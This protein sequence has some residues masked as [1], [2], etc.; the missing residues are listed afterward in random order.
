MFSPDE[1]TSTTD[2][3]ERIPR[4]FDR[5]SAFTERRQNILQQK[6]TDALPSLTQETSGARVAWRQVVQ[7]REENRRLRNEVESHRMGM[8][9]LL[10]DNT[11]LKDEYEQQI[12][13]IHKGYQQESA[14][15]QEHLQGSM[16][17]RNR[18][19]DQYIY[20]EQR[21]QEL[22]T[23]FQQASEE[24]AQK[25]LM[26]LAHLVEVAPD[27]ALA[28]LQGVINTIEMRV[29]QEKDR[30]VTEALY[31]RREVQRMID[32]LTQERSQLEEE[33][34]Q[35]CA[36]QVRAREQS[37]LRQKTVQGRLY[38]RWRVISL[39]TSLGLVALLVVLQFVCLLVFRVTLISS[40]TM[41]L[42]APIVICLILA[43]ISVSPLRMIRHMYMSGP[44]KKKAGA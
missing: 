43:L 17:E 2:A 38:A 33:R 40:I 11:R 42:L 36:L 15:Y 37:E 34:Q 21:H 39:L 28:Q 29:H 44:R 13:T 31:L 30:Y 10:A 7:L 9:Q 19:Q 23:M 20:L 27:D 35:L 22:L 32:T 25:R 5:R 3:L 14:H 1:V 6:Q 8:Q 12:A 16:G 4:T 18:L 24:E 41:A 26:E